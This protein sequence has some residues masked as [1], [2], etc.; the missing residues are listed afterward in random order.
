MRLWSLHPSLL[1]TKGIVAL[2]REA[3]LAKKVLENKTIGYK[4]HPQLIRFRESKNPMNAIN[5]YLEEVYNEAI[6]RNFNFDKSKF[7]HATSKQK[8]KVTSGQINYELRHLTKKVSARSPNHKIKIKE[9]FLSHPL[10]K[11]VGGEIEY[12]EI[13]P[14]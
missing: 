11:I 12:W 5:Y 7:E 2:W 6:K 10:F 4:N 9:N 3:L 13:L 8:I 1:D 14:K